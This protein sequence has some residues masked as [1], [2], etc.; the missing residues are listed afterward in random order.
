[1][2]ILLLGGNGYIGSHI[3]IE[4]LL[5]TNNN[6][7]IVDNLINS[8]LTIISK[9]QKITKKTFLFYNVDITNI[10][11]LEEV[12]EK[13]KIDKIIHLAALKSVSEST[14]N[15]L[16]YYDNNVNGTINVIKLM[17]KYH[18]TDIVF[19]SS[20][21]V[22]KSKNEPLTEDSELEPINPYGNTKYIIEKLLKDLYQSDN[23]YNCVILR[24]FNPIGNH[25]SGLIVDYHSSNLFAHICKS[26]INNTPVHIYGN[27]YDTVD[28]T[29]IRDY[30]HVVDLAQCHLKALSCKGYKLYNVGTGR[31]TSVLELITI[32]EKIYNKKIPYIYMARRSG[33]VPVYICNIELIK[34]ELE[35][36]PIYNIEDMCKDVITGLNHILYKHI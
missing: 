6:V 30:I 13:N 17:K 16:L 24:Y 26:I 29:G 20:A 1:M 7:I 14:I 22:Y 2:N 18:V 21:T 4:L 9:I 5:N 32:T 34:K 11:A 28:G 23:T 8:D 31:G 3:C 36:T 25:S 33:D 15:P 27:D 19:S 12:F 35:W 10:F